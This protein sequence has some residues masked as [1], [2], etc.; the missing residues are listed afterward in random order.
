MCVCVCIMCICEM[1]MCNVVGLFL[2][3]SL[4]VFYLCICVVCEC[5]CEIVVKCVL[6]VV[7]S[8]FV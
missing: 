4:L 2:S 5:I 8:L 6:F 1:C 7:V 3:C